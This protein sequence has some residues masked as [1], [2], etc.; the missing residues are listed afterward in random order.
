MSKAAPRGLFYDWRKVVNIR[1]LMAQLVAAYATRGIGHTTC[2]LRG[3]GERVE[4]A[5]IRPLLV[6]G[7]HYQGMH[8]APSIGRDN[9][10]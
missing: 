2:A 9:F 1:A 6:V 5:T 3:M 4:S 7:T 10:V 8:L